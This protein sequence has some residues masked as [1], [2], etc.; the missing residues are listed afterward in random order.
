M[1]I[2]HISD[3]HFGKHNESLAKDLL[4][5]V[6]KIKPDLIICT[7]D[8]VDNTRKD[9]FETANAYLH[10]LEAACAAKAGL[11]PSLIVVPGN[12]DYF[13]GGF[14][15]KDRKD[16]FGTYFGDNQ[17]D[18][19]FKKHGVWV[20]GFDSASEGFT[21]GG[22]LIR[23]ADLD[24]FHDRYR[25]L[26]NV[27]G[28]REAVKILAVHHHPL[29]VN[30]DTDWKQRW[31]TMTN[32]GAFLSAALLRKVDLVLH[33]HEH[34]Q[35]RAHLKS[36]LGGQGDWEVTVLS[37][38]ATLRKVENPEYNWFSVIKIDP[39]SVTVDFYSSEGLTFSDKPQPFVLRSSQ[40]R[41]ARLFAE[42]RVSKGYAIER[43]V[44][45]SIV[46][47]DGDVK[48]IVECEDLRRFGE[49]DP[50]AAGLPVKIP[51]TSGYI[52]KLRMQN[53]DLTFAALPADEQ[54]QEFET[55]ITGLSDGANF[56]YAWYAV[57]SFAMDTV[58]FTLQHSPTAVKGSDKTEFIYFPVYDP[59][60]ELTLVVQ[61]PEGF[62]PVKLEP[63]VSWTDKVPPR[64]WKPAHDLE[65]E[66]GA[67]KAVRFYESMRVASLR[68]QHPRLNVS[69]GIQWQVPEAPKRKGK[70]PTKTERQI[71]ALRNRWTQSTR[72]LDEQQAALLSLSRIVQMARVDLM[73]NWGGEIEASF[74]FFDYDTRSLAVL[75]A[76]LV[77]DQTKEIDYESYRMPYGMGIA[78]RAFKANRIRIYAPLDNADSE[79]PDYYYKASRREPWHAVLA[80]VPVQDPAAPENGPYGVLCL[81]SNDAECPL[82]ELDEREPSTESEEKLKQSLGSLNQM[83]I[84]EFVQIYLNRKAAAGP[85]TSGPKGG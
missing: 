27:E 26:E 13:K 55:S 4:S 21:G 46:T 28:F 19:Y 20:F 56:T 62:R 45:Y 51:Y 25:E 52:D 76:A 7:G 81:G 64:L 83:I 67:S 10:D 32:A 57:N 49:T 65:N 82:V 50:V 3:L 2:V 42:S 61:F 38:G 17:T 37:L 30:W 84:M 80:C 63:R 5:R 12:H 33:G 16:R 9:L 70:L 31:L 39:P 66:L 18:H 47:A 23:E 24:R 72:T 35:A 58:Q 75:A 71:Q 78:G 11:D 8:V 54:P 44:A 85:L 48:R 43:L 36:T 59:I 68:V 74:L 41:N 69:Y 77:G 14:L 29:P 22:G 15:F 1:K 79:E 34:L 73:N 60:E 40:E 53:P 6:R